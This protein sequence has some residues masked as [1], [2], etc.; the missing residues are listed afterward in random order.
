M[1]RIR[2]GLLLLSVVVVL[3]VVWYGLLLASY[4]QI[5]GELEKA[6][7]LMF[8]SV[9]RVTRQHGLAY[10]YD[11]DLVAAAQA[12]TAGVPS[13][14]QQPFPPN[15]PPFLHPALQLLAGLEYRPAY[16]WHAT[17]LYLL[18]IACLPVL[19]GALWK[20]GWS[21]RQVGVALAGVLL[22][23]PLFMSVLKGQDSALLLAGG[24]LWLSGLAREDDRLAGLGLALTLIRPQVAL[25]LALPFLFRRRRI[26]TWFCVGGLVLG[27]YSLLQVGWSGAMDYLQ[28]LAL[29]AGGE[30]Y[31]ISEAAMFNFT[32]LLLRLAPSLD[33][34]LVHA[35]G[36]GLYAAALIG[37]CVWWWVSP[38]IG[39][40]H[41]ALAVSLGLFAAPHLHYHDLALLAVPLLGLGL[42]A[43]RAGRMRVPPAAALPMAA[44]IILLFSQ[45]YDPVRFTIPYL[46]M[47]GLPLLTWQVDRGH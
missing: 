21:R 7:F 9:G 12:E 30:G 18:V 45:F 40:R 3:Q 41:A 38:G 44:S 8:Y 46:M 17:L 27:V 13:G 16:L 19:A 5:P 29:S 33:L 47:A 31:G 20:D 39:W 6:D 42:A 35:F 37:L 14:A 28:I 43:V 22:L 34:G 24:L 11:L 23:E 32:G 2:P 1:K 26:F 15:H 36:W 25:V 4:V 10:A